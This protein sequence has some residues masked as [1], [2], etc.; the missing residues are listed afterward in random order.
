M[1][2]LK[3]SA[4]CIV[5]HYR[6]QCRI[7]GI[8]CSFAHYLKMYAV[9]LNNVKP[10][11]RLLNQLARRRQDF[12]EFLKRFE[13]RSVRGILLYCGIDLVYYYAVWVVAAQY[14]IQSVKYNKTNSNMRYKKSAQ[15]N[16]S[17][18]N[19]VKQFQLSGMFVTARQCYLAQY[20]I[21][22]KAK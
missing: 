11:R 10:C 3:R 7:G 13:V 9:Y 21:V 1:R 6:T 5:W 4:S 16:C 8:F 19:T 2:M 15:R 18:T 20:N 14:T 17:S 12:A 22:Y